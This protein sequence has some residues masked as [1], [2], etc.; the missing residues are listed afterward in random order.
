MR[1]GNFDSDAPGGGQG[2][3]PWKPITVVSAGKSTQH[4]R[5]GGLIVFPL[6]LSAAPH[7]EWRACFA[8]RFGGSWSSND[9]HANLD[10]DSIE[11]WCE[12]ARLEPVVEWV[13]SKVM[14]TNE[15]FECHVLPQLLRNQQRADEAESARAAQESAADE[16]L[17]KLFRD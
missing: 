8:G 11:V 17:R 5:Y 2:E 7:D 16:K 15:N 9:P 4:P 1:I 13:K 3:Q 14:T 10:Y 12:P 6:H